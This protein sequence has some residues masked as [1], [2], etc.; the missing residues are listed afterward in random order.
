MRTTV[1][2]RLVGLVR[3]DLPLLLDKEIEEALS[4]LFYHKPRFFREQK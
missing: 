2:G 1:N 3:M 4:A